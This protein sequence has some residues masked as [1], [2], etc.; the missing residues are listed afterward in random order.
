MTSQ[1]PDS[2][3][4]R[5][6]RGCIQRLN[7]VSRAFVFLGEGWRPGFYSAEKSHRNVGIGTWLSTAHLRTVPTN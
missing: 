1:A 6:I 7:L 5:V 4:P 2:I 3:H